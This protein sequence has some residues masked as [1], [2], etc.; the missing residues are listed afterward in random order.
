MLV[1]MG[2]SYTLVVAMRSARCQWPVPAGLPRRRA[3]CAAIL[4]VLLAGLAVSAAAERDESAPAPSAKPASISSQDAANIVRQAYGGRIVATT[5]STRTIAG[6]KHSG[7]RV[8]AD[9]KGRVKT[10]FV[11]SSGRIHDDQQRD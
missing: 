2:W 3:L 1:R 7:F 4:A 5:A 8:R 11:D 10:V 9:V 6:K